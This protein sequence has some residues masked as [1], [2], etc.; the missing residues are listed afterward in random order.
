MLDKDTKGIIAT[1]EPEY[2][3][4]NS[5]IPIVQKFFKRQT[6]EQLGG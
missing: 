1:G 5:E 2:L 6:D 3:R 4:D